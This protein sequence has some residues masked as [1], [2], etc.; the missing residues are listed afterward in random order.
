MGHHQVQQA[1]GDN[2]FHGFKLLDVEISS[3]IFIYFTAICG[4][5]TM[6]FEV[7]VVC[8]GRRYRL[9]VEAAP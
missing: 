6:R 1:I 3:S 5:K 7:A 4:E 9:L 8:R 2:I